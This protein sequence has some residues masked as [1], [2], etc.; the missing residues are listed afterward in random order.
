LLDDPEV[1]ETFFN[2]L[3]CSSLDN[4]QNDVILVT[5]PKGVGKTQLVKFMAHLYHINNP[6]N[7]IIGLC[8]INSFYNDLPYAIKVD[9]DQVAEEESDKFKSDFSG[10]PDTSEFKDSLVIFDDTERHPNPKVERML[11][12]LCNVLVQNGRNF[13]VCFVVILHQLDGSSILLNGGGL[14][15]CIAHKWVAHRLLEISQS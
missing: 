9:L 2:G 14:K 15:I 10:I 7:R 4:Q 12:Q 1:Y 8:C 13:I 3:C 6:E 5:G 11:Y